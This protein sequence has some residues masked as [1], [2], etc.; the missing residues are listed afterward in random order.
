M[1]TVE[2]TVGTNMSANTQQFSDDEIV[3]NFGAG[4][5]DGVPMGLGGEK[6]RQSEPASSTLEADIVSA[7]PKHEEKSLP[8][9][10]IPPDNAA[11]SDKPTPV[12]DVA[13]DDGKAKA[14][15]N[16]SDEPEASEFPDTLLQ[17]AGFS[18]AEDAR[19]LGFKDPES[20]L[21]AVQWQGRSLTQPAKPSRTSYLEPRKTPD[22]QPTTI[23]AEKPPQGDDLAFKPFKPSNPE[24][25]D[26]ELLKL[27]EAQNQ[28]HAAQFEA[29][30]RRHAAQID[31]VASRLQGRDADEQQRQIMQQVE[32][33]DQTVQ[34]LG[35]EWEAEFGKGGGDTLFGRT[36]AESVAAAQNRVDLFDAV[37]L[38]RRANEERGGKPMTVQQE[39]QWALMQRYPD[40][41]RQQLLRQ[42]QASAEARKGTQA[43]R[44]TARTTP[45]GTRNERLLS[46]L[47]QKYPGVDFSAGSG[48]FE[49]D[50]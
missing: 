35:A 15:P 8:G 4:Q 5:D 45:Q 49:G 12:Q 50:I 23:P 32:Q 48:E 47:Q 21:A 30:N 9:V 16:V 42:R 40:K 34:G 14:T 38:L 29:Q 31:Q 22:T 36:N 39:V 26:E 7:T 24:L 25:F 33:F 46:A 10:D 43:S 3:D 20:L 13:G 6:G 37:N 19:K 41:F 44:P 11:A 27:I 17:M 28:H 18:S 1:A 2:T